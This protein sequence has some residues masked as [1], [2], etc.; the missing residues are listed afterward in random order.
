MFFLPLVVFKIFL[1]ITGF[2]QFNYYVSWYTFLHGPFDCGF[3]GL[4]ERLIGL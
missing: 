1:L 4:F 2:E 3:I